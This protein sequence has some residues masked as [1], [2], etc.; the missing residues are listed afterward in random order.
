MELETESRQNTSNFK[1]FH[2]SNNLSSV[3][4]ESKKSYSRFKVI[5]NFPSY[6]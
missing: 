5:V 2:A 4:K 6:K 3:N 1:E